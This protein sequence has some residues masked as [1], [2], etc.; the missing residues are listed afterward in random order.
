MNLLLLLLVSLATD[1]TGATPSDVDTLKTAR[2]LAEKKYKGYTYGSSGGKQIDCTR[3]VSAVVANLARQCNV[4]LAK[5]DQRTLAVVL[6]DEDGEKLQKLVD[7]ED[8]KIRGVQQALVNAGLGVAVN[9][10]DAKAGDLVQYWF[11]SGGKWVGHAGLVEK[12]E[13]GKATIYGSHKTTLQ[14]E[15]KLERSRRK[16]GIGSGPVFDLTDA[17]RKVF[18]VRW[19]KKKF[20]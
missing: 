19:T 14:S 11:Q 9:P 10:K 17:K 18:V 15:R 1:V 13:D 7:I 3:F 8:K 6:S 5:S 12:V 20:D 4:K 2:T 16:G